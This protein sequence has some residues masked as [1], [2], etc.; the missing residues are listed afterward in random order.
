MRRKMRG[1][2]WREEQAKK[3]LGAEGTEAEWTVPSDQGPEHAVVRIRN[4]GIDNIAGIRKFWSSRK[5]RQ[6]EIVVPSKIWR[7]CG[8]RNDRWVAG[9]RRKCWAGDV[10]DGADK[11]STP[12]AGRQLYPRSEQAL[13]ESGLF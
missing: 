1:W 3:T 2:D 6:G 9:A 13:V 11:G 7:D 5:R 10:G 12:L 8:R 4:L